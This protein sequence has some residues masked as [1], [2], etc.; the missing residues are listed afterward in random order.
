MEAL[1][2]FLEQW[3]R[4]EFLSAEVAEEYSVCSLYVTCEL[5]IMCAAALSIIC[6][7]VDHTEIKLNFC[8]ICLL[9]N[10]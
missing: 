7:S 4:T 10:D 9:I 1:D 5:C 6:T 3:Q 2:V 8:K